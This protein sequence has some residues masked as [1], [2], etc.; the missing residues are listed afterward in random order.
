MEP[1]GF[2]PIF[3][4]DVKMKRTLLAMAAMILVAGT[5][6]T[7]TAA[8]LDTGY[9]NDMFAAQT[10]ND[11]F[12]TS[13]K[14]RLS[15]ARMP[16]ENF[17]SRMSAAPLSSDSALGA[18]GSSYSSRRQ[19]DCVYYNGFTVWGDIYGAWGRQR[20][21][22]DK[23]GYKNHVAGPALGF[24]WSN[25]SF[26][27]GVATTYNRGKIKGLDR[28]HDRDT[29]TWA[30]SGYGQWSGRNL[31]VNANITYGYNRYNGSRLDGNSY[32][33][34]S[35]HSNSWNLAAEAGYKIPLGAFTVT[36]NIG[37]RYFHDKREDVSESVSGMHGNGLFVQNR[38]YHV[39]EMPLGVV[40]AYEIRTSGM[41]LI[42]QARFSW[43]PEF[44]RRRGVANGYCLDTNKSWSEES[45]KHGRNASILGLG[46]QAKFSEMISGGLDYNLELRDRKYEHRLNLGIGFSF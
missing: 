25:G 20:S 1:V 9:D 32:M 42:P 19:L 45:P 18:T 40:A 44:D 29:K 38:N 13:V 10:S 33:E 34:S 43:V 39:F 41:T 37:L 5:S 21:K 24:D 14:Q 31:Y 2:Q 17:Y 35:Y 22:D 26:T 28:P 8:A 7:T 15:I 27:A 30:L 6:Y 4:E 12:L 46:L 11:A 23:D 16:N 3:P 36:P